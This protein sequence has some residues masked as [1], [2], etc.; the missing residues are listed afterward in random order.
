MKHTLLKLAV[1]A[2]IVL[3][4]A[5]LFLLIRDEQQ[6]Q[7]QDLVLEAQ[8]IDLLSPL[9]RE[10]QGLEADLLAQR[11]Q[12]DAVQYAPSFAALLVAAQ[13]ADVIAQ[14]REITDKNRCNPLLGITPADADAW[15]ANGLPDWVSACMEDGWALCP[16]VASPAEY[17]AL[18]AQLAALGLSAPRIARCTAEFL[19]SAEEDAFARLGAALLLHG[20][21][22]SGAADP[23]WRVPTFDRLTQ[24]A[25]NHYYA[26]VGTGGG[27]VFTFGES[28]L[29]GQH[30]LTNF[31]ALAS[32]MNRDIQSGKIHCL[33][34]QDALAARQAV[35][36]GL[37]MMEEWK[38]NEALL[39]SSLDAINARIQL[40]APAAVLAPG[41]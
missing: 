30:A 14:A 19:S 39:Q 28:L 21:T 18:C 41:E 10:K 16:M 25:L 32:L 15:A 13:S 20:G 38:A 33:A 37:A 40:I 34:P 5:Q 27:V 31:A 26:V 11:Q 4:A 2:A 6:H 7:A 12:I 3:L 17:E 22:E 8:Q 24:E 1:A 35:V 29:E 23:L 36:A 9:L